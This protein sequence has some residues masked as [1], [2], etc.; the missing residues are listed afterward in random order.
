MPFYFAYG[1]NMDERQMRD[2]CP[3][4][5]FVAVARLDSTRLC[6]PRYSEKRN[7]GIASIEESP[8]D[9]VWGVIFEIP[10]DEIPCLDRSE[11]YQEGRPTHEN[12]YN[13]EKRNIPD[14][15][16]QLRPCLIY[17]ANTDKPYKP[18]LE[19]YLNYIIRGAEQHQQQGI[20]HEYVEQ[21]WRIEAK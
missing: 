19:C 1:S 16:G 21:L 5:R 11:G 14:V 17:I 12:S 6:F 13:P 3:H 18:S 9:V 20:P 15:N 7:G 8:G 2:R 10:A 4:A